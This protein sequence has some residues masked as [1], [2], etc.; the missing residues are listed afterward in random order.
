VSDH[1]G[2]RIS[3]PMRL[4]LPS[5]PVS[6]T[7]TS[8]AT[9]LTDPRA[10]LKKNAG[11]ASSASSFAE[12]LPNANEPA[13]KTGKA[14]NALADQMTGEAAVL[15]SGYMLLVQPPTDKS[16]SLAGTA[17]APAVA[18]ATGSEGDLGD[19][20]QSTDKAAFSVPGEIGRP[21]V[22][23]MFGLSA[24]AGQGDPA[25]GGKSGLQ[26]TAKFGPEDASPTATATH[27]VSATTG[28][29]E[30]PQELVAKM[31]AKAVGPRDLPPASG[32]AYNR[33]ETVITANK[34]VLA[35]QNLPG[36][37]ASSV[38]PNGNASVQSSA[39]A[40]F[41]ANAPASAE[42]NV[43]TGG[44]AAIPEVAPSRPMAATSRMRTQ[45]RPLGDGEK[46][47]VTGSS[48]RKVDNSGDTA[49]NKNFL[50]TDDEA[51][52]PSE[53]GLGTDVAKVSST[54]PATPHRSSVSAGNPVLD[55]AAGT[56]LPTDPQVAATTAA[57]A[58]RAVDAVLAA[59]ERL[60][61]SSS[62]AVNLQFSFGGADLAV[63]VEVRGGEVHATF[64]TNSPELR[65]S[66]SSEWH[67]AAAQDSASPLRMVE[68]VFRGSDSSSLSNFTGESGT[69]QRNSNA[70]ESEQNN[71]G[72]F[73]RGDSASSDDASSSIPRLGQAVQPSTSLRLHTFA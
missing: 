70:R 32:S 41:E 51:L 6:P 52:N 66:L 31:A 9:D 28:N 73:I 65:D 1:G 10:G 2:Q 58:H 15:F 4:S 14:A 50:S 45:G 22:G 44:L 63:R 48:N 56:Q 11:D 37:P 60:G 8:G 40:L 57:D 62:R 30:A 36:I 17:T 33:G 47:A 64:R 34:A 53:D 16:T 61:T 3:I 72:S 55:T 54:M 7:P 59:T 49:I 39:P 5:I 29:G 13:V 19:T 21:A 69:Q 25:V 20:L 27:A 18:E 12:L 23:S 43:P 68:P 24:K 67:A 42:A 35:P 46:I 71:F 38:Q 26:A